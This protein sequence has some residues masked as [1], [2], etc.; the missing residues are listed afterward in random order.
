MSRADRS[1]GLRVSRSADE[2]AA[3]DHEGFPG[4][5]AALGELEN[6]V[7][8]FGGV[9]DPAEGIDAAAPFMRPVAA[10]PGVW[11]QGR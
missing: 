3:A 10:L 9:G 1:L 2:A 4:D 8:D 5:V 7:G 6:P 11:T